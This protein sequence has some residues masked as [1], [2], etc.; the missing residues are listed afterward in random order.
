MIGAFMAAVIGGGADYLEEPLTLVV[1][2][3]TANE[4]MTIPCGNTGA[5]NALLDWGD[6]TASVPVTTFNSANLSH[7]YAV[8]GDYSVRVI[9]ALPY[10]RFAGNTTFGPKLRAVRGGL[11]HQMLSVDAAFQVCGNLAEISLFDTSA[12]TNFINFNPINSALKELP[13]FDLRAAQG[14]HAAWNVCSALTTVPAGFFD[15]IGLP[16]PNC[17]TA[18]FGFATALTIQSIEN[19]VAS[20]VTSGRFAPATNKT[21]AL[22][23]APTLAT[24]QGHT[25]IMAAVATLKSR[26]WEP[27][28]KGT[29]L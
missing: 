6:G 10:I 3:T 24:I 5:Y 27:S 22:N 21:I 7:V 15:V 20:I 4:T 12:C 25:A 17:F 28:Y 11:R 1:R 13:K 8:P 19:I 9:G 23:G 26:G 2:T 29:A 14:F 16:A 18:V